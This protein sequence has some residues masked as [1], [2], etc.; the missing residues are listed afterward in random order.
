M[1]DPCVSKDF[2]VKWMNDQ[3]DQKKKNRAKLLLRHDADNC[4][5]PPAKRRRCEANGSSTDSPVEDEVHETPEGLK[6]V[7]GMNGLCVDFVKEHFFLNAEDD[8]GICSDRLPRG[9]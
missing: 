5:P 3:E 4:T 6:L 9:R 2:G 1:Y 8:E 7:P